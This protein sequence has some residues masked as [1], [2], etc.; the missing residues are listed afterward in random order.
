MRSLSLKAFCLMMILILSKEENY[1]YRSDYLWV[2]VPDHPDWLY[3]IGEQAKIEVAFYL[4]GIPQD[5]E[6]N[7]EIGPDML[8]SNSQG[9]ATL[10]NG[11]T[12]IDIGTMLRPGFLDLRLT[13]KIGNKSY[14]HH[15]KVGFSPELLVPYTVNPSDFDD[16]WK[17]TIENARKTKLTY[18]IEK[19]DKYSTDE[20]NT[21]LLKIRTD[22]NHYIYG[23]LTKPIDDGTG[24]KYPVVLC[25]PGAGV[26]TIKE[27]MRNT[28][29]VKNGFI[30]LEIEIHGLH[31]EM[32][33]EQFEE[34]ST[35]FGGVN[36][37]LENGID[38]RENYYMKH[39]YVACVRAMDYLTSLPEWDGKNAFVQG[40][41]KVGPF[42]LFLLD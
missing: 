15:I 26:K 35:A 12:I 14:P 30:R 21:F 31:P 22:N 40:E 13:A 9:K 10:E 32:A 18:T 3:R 20:F 2:T 38:N 8:P 4:Y 11:K 39:V 6:I 33:T 1:P 27:P 25:P 41:V 17:E 37:Y 5:I 7:Y 23:Y 28:F 19:V 36:Y 29:Y 24:K 34:I 42:Q 16:F